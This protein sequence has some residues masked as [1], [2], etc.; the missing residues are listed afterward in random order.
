M[1]ATR[2][3]WSEASPAQWRALAAAQA[4]WMLDAMDVMLFT[5]ALNAI[6][7]QFHLSGAAIGSLAAVSLLASAAGGILFGFLADRYGRARALRWSILLYSLTTALTATSR[8]PAEML[9]WR[10]LLGLGLGGEWSAGSVLVAE[11]WPARHRGK[12]IGIMQSG[13]AVGYLLAALLAGWILPRWGWRALFAVGAVPALLVIWIRRNVEEPEVWRKGLRRRGQPTVSLGSVR[14]RLTRATLLAASVLFAY[15]GLFTW[16][17]AYL[18]APRD[19][20]GAG[21]SLVKTS[22]W[23][24]PVQ[25]GALLGYI[26]FGFLAD[27]FG[28]RVVFVCFVAGAAA[29]VPLYG[30]AAWSASLLLVLG[31]LVGFFGHGY[32]S[33]FGAMLAELF[34]S[35]VRAT[36]QGLAYNLGRAV[37]A[38]A[39]IAIGSL[40]DRW[41]IGA[42]LGLT[43]A[44]FLLSAALVF[45]LPETRATELS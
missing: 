30:W 23:M 25:I 18:G 17:P 37:S 38:L 5:F 4:G 26:S 45:L 15:W 10:L 31:P 11:V 34:P 14:G 22:A 19:Q 21:L 42:A 29:L 28:R 36:A 35:E 20:G 3:W 16:L 32:F 7:G 2:S 1:S 6:R 24:V 39:P 9:V 41:G 8:N 43:S 13:W 40:A 27:R 33:L 12:A 44:F